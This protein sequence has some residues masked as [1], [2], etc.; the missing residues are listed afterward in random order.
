VRKTLMLAGL[1][2]AGFTD[3]AAA[4]TS[5]QP[6]PLAGWINSEFENLVVDCL[7]RPIELTPLRGRRPVPVAPARYTPDAVFRGLR[8]GA[9]PQVLLAADGTVTREFGRVLTGPTEASAREF[10]NPLQL[11]YGN[12]D[13]RL[14][15]LGRSNTV[16]T[17]TCAS[18]INAVAEAN[19]D[20]SIP[21][22]Q[23]RAAVAA[24]YD[25][26]TS[27]TLSFSYGSFESPVWS[28]L[29]QP[30]QRATEVLQTAMAI[31]T[32]YKANPQ[33]ISQNNWITSR[34]DGIALY[35]YAGMR[36]Q[37]EA[38][39]SGA[40][41][42][43]F[44][45]FKADA[46]AAGAATVSAEGTLSR[47]QLGYV[48]DG[49]R[50]GPIRRLERLPQMDAVARLIE[51]NAD[52]VFEPGSSDPVIYDLTEK[53][54]NFRVR[55]MPEQVCREAWSTDDPRTSR[56]ETAFGPN[57]EDGCLFTAKVNPV[58][59]DLASG[60][61][62]SPTFL[63]AAGSGGEGGRLRLRPRE[64]FLPGSLPPFARLDSGG[65]SVQVDER[66]IPGVVKLTWPALVLTV[67][68]PS[69]LTVS[70]ITINQM[71]LICGAETYSARVASR[72]YRL[73]A[74]NE[75]STLTVKLEAELPRAG[76]QAATA[77]RCQLRPELT[78]TLSNGRTV[79]RRDRLFDLS[80]ATSP[81][82]PPQVQV[83]TA[84]T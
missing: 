74:I 18:T 52:V 29:N 49:A 68:S 71:E 69:S 14:V 76:Y 28:R 39:V 64:I 67:S 50:G 20:F 19:A 79:T 35:E 60:Y 65:Y 46:R 12:L 55:G 23:F 27:R 77:G 1:A 57:V 59:A 8:L 47:F 16:Y 33:Q 37:T 66:T 58:Q 78:F 34:F 42:S 36:I 84:P 44:L 11:P 38:S 21:V 53:T 3:P 7:T 51:R 5:P 81:A 63:S 4:Q 73:G 56:F 48:Y 26:S 40:G 24:D 10:A 54:L 6:R 82:P 9:N 22:A 75:Q 61:A 32:W 43:G 13:D 62:F 30:N 45:V 70:A 83:G 2:L 31:W 15:E 25:S 80:V 17:H 41:S 72:D